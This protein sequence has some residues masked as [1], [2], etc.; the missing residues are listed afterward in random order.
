MTTAMTT[1]MKTCTKCGIEK[2]VTEFH[3]KSKKEGRRRSECRECTAKY[4]KQ[5]REANIDAIHESC[6]R[7][8]K[9]HRKERNA[10]MREWRKKNEDKYRAHKQRYY[11]KHRDEILA[12]KAEYYQRNRAVIRAKQNR[13]HHEKCKFKNWIK[14]CKRSQF[15][16]G[17]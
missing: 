17:K 15:V 9:A 8:A 2:P 14:I 11:E 4:A 6:T 7:W 12:Q 1:E 13:R 16:T 5:Y 10:Y 3:W